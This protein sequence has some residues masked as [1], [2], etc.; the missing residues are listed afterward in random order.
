M[1]RLG[2]FFPL[3]L[4]FVSYPA[5]A[6]DIAQ[7]LDPELLTGWRTWL[8]L[9]IQWT[10]LLAFALWLGL[11]LGTL[12]LGM[13]PPQDYLLYSSWILFLVLL[14]TGTYNMEW[15]AGIPET[16]SL[17]LLSLLKT[18]PY[19]VTYSVVLAVKWGLY[20]L[21]ILLTLVITILHLQGRMAEAKTT[22]DISPSGINLGCPANL[23]G[24][25]S[26]FLSRGRGSMADSNPLVGRCYGSRRSP[27]SGN[28]KPGG[29]SSQ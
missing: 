19:G 2:T 13:N 26:A 25:C 9:T 21:A 11:T 15:S 27:R 7:H 20:V 24:R 22:K 23:G 29:S 14:A 8:H 17:F 18:I 16:P 3:F 6:H 12:L 4:V 10:H 1:N 5:F 28:R